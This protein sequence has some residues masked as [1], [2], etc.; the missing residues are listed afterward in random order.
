VVGTI[1]LSIL[2]EILTRMSN[3][4]HVA[5]VYIKVPVGTEQVGFALMMLLVLLLKPDGL[6]G[7]REFSFERLQEALRKLGVRLGRPEPL[8][9]DEAGG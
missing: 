8:G 5:G 7:G 2:A 3:G 9:A 4:M 6:T 1:V